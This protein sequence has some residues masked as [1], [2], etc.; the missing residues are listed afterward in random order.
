MIDPVTA[1]AVISGLVGTLT[2][3][4]NYRVGM[5][6]AEQKTAAEPAKPDDTTLKQGEQVLAT[7]E[8]AVATHG[9]PAEQT[10]LTGY[11]QAP[12]M[13]QPLLE[14][15]LTAIAQ[16]APD[17]AQQLQTLARDHDVQTGGVTVTA[18]GERSVAGV[19]FTNSPISTGDT[20][21]PKG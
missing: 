1:G 21:Q 6:Q 15:A 16:R 3:Y 17:V 20:T 10:A 5:K 18:S 2:A 12:T 7:V 9:T 8:S 19:N 4:M 11:Q 14:Q 13:Y